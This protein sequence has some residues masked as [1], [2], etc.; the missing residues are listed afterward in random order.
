[1]VR[2]TV[3][4]RQDGWKE[5]ICQVKK[6]NWA[7]VELSVAEIYLW[8]PSSLSDHC[9]RHRK[10][11][12][13]E[14]ISYRVRPHPKDGTPDTRSRYAVTRIANYER[15]RCHFSLFLFHLVQFL[16]VIIRFE[17]PFSA[18]VY[19]VSY[20]THV[21]QAYPTITGASCLPSKVAR[22]VQRNLHQAQ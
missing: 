3:P 4:S 9:K 10:E 19:Q 21:Q 13:K 2:N 12:S 20:P 16:I 14:G 17:T 7:Y 8:R 11:R 5:Q 22:R 15:T 6:A 1:M 18:L